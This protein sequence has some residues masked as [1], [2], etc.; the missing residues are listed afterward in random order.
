MADAT[1]ATRDRPCPF[2][3]AEFGT[4]PHADHPLL[5]ALFAPTDDGTCPYYERTDQTTCPYF[6]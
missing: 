6:D 2:Y 5:S 4:C 3:D 1:T